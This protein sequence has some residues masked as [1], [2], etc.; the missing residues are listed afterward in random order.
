MLLKIENIEK[1]FPLSGG[2]FVKRRQPVLRGVS[3]DIEPGECLGIVGESGSGKSTLG[4]IILGIETP[5]AGRIVPGEAM[6][7]RPRHEAI[8][9]VFQDYTSS[10]NPRFTV[11]QIIAEPLFRTALNDQERALRI[12][13]LLDEVGLSEAMLNRYPHQLS[14]GQL[15]RVC[16][17]RAIAPNPLFILFDEAVSSLDVSVQ[18]KVLDLLLDIKRRRNLSYLFITHDITVAA[19][20]CDRL[21]F[22]NEGRVVEELR[23]LT[24]IGHVEHEY[25]R[26]L[27]EAASYLEIPY[28]CH[29]S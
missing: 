24:R 5:D 20:V 29:T 25:T 13:Q 26:Q 8:S 6:H 4:K 18:V 10:V 11:Q 14:G 3:F 1:S 22:F 28:A 23:D 15:Q 16:I 27:L 21:M 2:L 17:A 7:Q 19:Y 9:V 12:R